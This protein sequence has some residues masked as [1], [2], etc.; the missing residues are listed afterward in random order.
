MPLIQAQFGPCEALKPHAGKPRSAPTA[1]GPGSYDVAPS[2]RTQAANFGESRSLRFTSN[3][4]SLGS[5]YST[6]SVGRQVIK[7]TAPTPTF[8]RAARK[9]TVAS[10]G[11]GPSDYEWSTTQGRAHAFSGPLARFDRFATKDEALSPG[12]MAYSL[13]S[14]FAK[15]GTVVG[16]SERFMTRP[17]SQPSF[18]ELEHASPGPNVYAG[19]SSFGTQVVSGARSSSTSKFG[20]APRFRN[21]RVH[22]TN[23]GPGDYSANRTY[24][25]RQALSRVRT[26]PQ[27]RFGTSRR[28]RV[29]DTVL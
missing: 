4:T 5:T 13:P 25:G 14:T 29:E 7:S 12:P 10:P 8:G 17:K 6:S 19:N 1:P 23:P 18:Y 11:P 15:G 20:S 22:A 24:F 9:P 21:A 27:F 16:T 3:T 26:A 28:M 2:G